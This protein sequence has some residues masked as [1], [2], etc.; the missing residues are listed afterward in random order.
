MANEASQLIME[1]TRRL[2]ARQEAN[3][4]TL[5][6][7][8]SIILA[9]ASVVAAVFGGAVEHV[10][11]FNHDASIAAFVLFALTVTACLY[12]LWPRTWHFA[13][14]LDDW[15]ERLKQRK[16]PTEEA[17]LYNLAKYFEGQ[18]KQ[19][20][21]QLDCLEWWFAGACAL[22]GFQVVAWAIAIL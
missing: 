14:D 11:E 10:A 9:G 7:R 22:L 8:V 4:D 19:N 3:L 15:I 2:L 13:H 18:R 1:E 21:P 16:P 12:V 5:R 6:G 17:V 20:Q